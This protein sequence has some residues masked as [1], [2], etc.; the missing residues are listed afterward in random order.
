MNFLDCEAP[1][2]GER[3]RTIRRRGWPEWWSKH[4]D[5]T[6]GEVIRRLPLGATVLSLL[7]F[8]PW[9]GKAFRMSLRI[10]SA[11]TRTSPHF[12]A[13]QTPATLHAASSMD[14]IL[15]G[16]RLRWAQ[17]WVI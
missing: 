13:Y 9:Q 3:L 14:T 16:G 15:A 10:R 8:A 17:G 1:K 11:R 4:V 6:S 7:R 12:A 5:W 2:Q